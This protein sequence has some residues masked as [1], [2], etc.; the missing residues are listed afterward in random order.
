PRPVVIGAAVHLDTAQRRLAADADAGVALEVDPDGPGLAAE[1]RGAPAEPSLAP[2]RSC[3][4]LQ[5]QRAL[6]SREPS[7]A[8]LDRRLD[9]SANAL[10]PERARLGL[11][12][13]RQVRV[14]LHVQGVRVR[15]P[16]EPDLLAAGPQ[17]GEL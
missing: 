1:T 17:E 5:V 12:L 6:E 16:A 9:R 4:D 15:R 13:E 8:G 11:H 7:G 3:L 14:H 2:D 10:E